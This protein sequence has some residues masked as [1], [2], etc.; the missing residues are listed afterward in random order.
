MRISNSEAQRQ[1]ID[2]AKAFL[3]TKDF[4]DFTWKVGHVQPD[5]QAEDFKHR[6][7]YVKWSVA[8]ELSRNGAAVDGGPIVLVDVLRNE[9]RF[10]GAD[11]A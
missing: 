2:L 5:L 10:F 11:A 1:A 8:I 4:R 9:C 7:T 3:A 6:K